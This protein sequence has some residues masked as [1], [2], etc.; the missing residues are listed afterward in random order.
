[1]KDTC[2]VPPVRC[3]HGGHIAA[4]AIEAEALATARN[5]ARYDAALP[6]CGV[7]GDTELFDDFAA[8]QLAAQRLAGLPAPRFPTSNWPAIATDVRNTL[9]NSAT[10]FST[11]TAQALRLSLQFRRT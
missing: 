1:M 11:P 4:A 9:F 5:K 2:Q 7:L 6:M 3:F 8:Y 10:S